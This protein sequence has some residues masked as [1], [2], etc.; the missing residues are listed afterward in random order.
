M[1]LAFPNIS[2][3]DVM[4]LKIVSPKGWAKNGVLL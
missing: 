2:G 3:N 4:I 1:L